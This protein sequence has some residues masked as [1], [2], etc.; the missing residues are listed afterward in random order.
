[1]PAVVAPEIGSPTPVSTRR[2]VRQAL[3]AAAVSL[4]YAAVVLAVVALRHELGDLPRPWLVSY[5][6]AWLVGFGLPVWVSLVPRTGSM[7]PRWRLGRAFA[8]VNAIGFVAAGLLVP[9]SAPT[10]LDRGLASAHGCL[11]IGLVT[12]ILPVV[13]GTLLLRGAAPV[14]SRAT[15]AALGASGGALGGLVLHLHCPIADGVHL[16]L[17]HGSVVAIAAL[18]AAAL[19]PRALEP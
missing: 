14:G 18:L 10:S 11:S 2:P 9:R 16:G 15:A 12:A 1:M 7:M 3:L 17:V 4:A 19:V 13:V 5:L 6:A 8:I